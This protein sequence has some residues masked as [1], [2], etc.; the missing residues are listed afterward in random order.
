MRTDLSEDCEQ[1]R[2]YEYPWAPMIT[3]YLLEKNLDSYQ[4]RRH[5]SDHIT[6]E[7]KISAGP[8]IESI[9]G[10]ESESCL[11]ERW[12]DVKREI[13]RCTPTRAERRANAS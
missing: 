1:T 12:V 13:V 8:G 11:E 6:T 5:D 2:S 3:C 7:F 4:N 10:L 9:T